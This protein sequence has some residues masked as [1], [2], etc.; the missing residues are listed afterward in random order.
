MTY[1]KL[2]WSLLAITVL[3]SCGKDDD[4]PPPP[5]PPTN[6]APVIAAQNFTVSENI[7]DTAAIGTVKAT[8]KDG[9][10]LTFSIQTNSD[11]LF[12]ITGAGVLSLASGKKLSFATK[13]SHSLTVQVSDGTDTA[14]AAVTVNVTEATGEEPVNEAPT[15]EDQNL[16][17]A[18]DATAGDVI[19][20]AMANDADE[21]ELTYALLTDES[22]LFQVAEN[23]EISLA[24]GT[25]LDF[26]TVAEYTLTLT[27][28]DGTNVPVE[29]M[30]TIAVTD[31][32]EAP[33][34]ED[35]SF[36]VA[37]DQTVVG[38]VEGSDP[39]GDELTF[40]LVTDESELFHV[41]E[42][43]EITLAEGK[44][45]DFETAT[46]HSLTLSVSDGSNDPVEFTVTVTV[47]N[48]IESLFEDPASFILKFEVTAGQELEIGLNTSFEY[49]YT[50]DWG[51]GTIENF[52]TNDN[53]L[54][55]YE[56]AD[57]Y[58]V[59]IKGTFPALRMGNADSLSGDALIDVV[60]WGTQKW[61][62]MREAFA[63]CDN[64]EQFS[65]T[66][67]PDWSETTTMRQMFLYANLF[68]GDI[69][70]WVTTNVTTMETMFEGAT[71]F[72]QD[73]GDWDV[74]NVTNMFGMFGYAS[75]FNQDL[76]GWDTSSVTDMSYMFYNATAF[77]QPLVQTDG[78]WNT[79][80]VTDMSF[81][82]EGATNFNQSLGSWDISSVTN[83]TEMLDNCGMST[84]NLNAT[85]IGWA[86]FVE[87]NNGPSNITLGLEGLTTCGPDVIAASQTFGF[88]GWNTVG[89]TYLVNC[90]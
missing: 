80:N 7:S 18:E 1:K 30:V 19:G 62:S 35:K 8:D 24:E 5:P 40:A 15:A 73:I 26:E 82:F 32:N 55:L 58:R 22:E 66:D 59:A 57:T 64:L 20:T 54:H 83:M 69:G 46:E 14:S 39:E 38:T 50:I 27:V 65:A 4:T 29:F 71:S 87:A 47:T 63:Y 53:P 85:L 75:A 12:E 31:V 45:L 84:E 56:M 86:N 10:D 48:V 3:W 9:D 88:Y 72:N 37:E 49:D 41:A 77:N 44:N 21:D 28:S 60:Q 25:S 42:N 36:E 67:P 90:P 68:N 6:T 34:A 61:Q 81:M 70:T 13:A 33:S 16:E 51:D 2:L 52:S 23:G 11:N 74:S 43:G 76:S 78:G 79:S 89:Q 17:V